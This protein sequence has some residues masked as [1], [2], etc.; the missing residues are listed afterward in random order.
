MYAVPFPFA[1]IRAYYHI[2]VA[3]A[4]YDRLIRQ[5]PKSED[6]SDLKEQPQ[7]LSLQGLCRGR[8]CVCPKTR[9]AKIDSIFQMSTEPTK[10]LIYS[11]LRRGR[12]RASKIWVGCSPILI[13][14]E[15]S[16]LN[17]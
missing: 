14:H 6:V 8:S 1:V 2:G 11:A 7:G 4:T 10:F 9:G 12:V 5:K 16:V 15:L 13:A 3:N 17:M